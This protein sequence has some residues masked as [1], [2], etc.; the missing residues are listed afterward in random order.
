MKTK[1]RLLLPLALLCSLAASAQVDRQ[2]FVYAIKNGDTLRLDKYDTPRPHAEAKPCIIFVFGGSFMRGSR[3]ASRYIPFYTHWARRGYTVAAIDY[4]LGLKDVRT[5][6][7]TKQRKLKLFN[8]FTDLFEETVSMAVEDLFDA[9]R[10]IV[11][12]ADEWH[13]DTQRI[14][15]CGSS[16]GA[17]T[18]LQ[19]EYEICNHTARAAALP[20]GFRYAGIISFAG[21]IFSEGKM[22]WATRPAPILFFHGDADKNVPCDKIKFMR[23][24]LYGPKPITAQLEAMHA[25]YCFRLFEN[26]EHEIATNPMHEHLDEIA[27]FLDKFVD[28]KANLYVNTTETVAG[29]PGRKKK[30]KLKDCL[31]ANFNF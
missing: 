24:G 30:I 28:G 22:T 2:T 7:D 3:D 18:V 23:F 15:A 21:C 19:G 20:D 4:R 29:Q 31:K 16:A 5:K 11:A 8:A 26:A 6:I 27:L 14:T 12:H 13:I 17:I 25:P 1:L 9:T 10:F